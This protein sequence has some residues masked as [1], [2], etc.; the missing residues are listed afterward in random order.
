MADI[1]QSPLFLLTLSLLMFQCG[2][3][4]YERCNHF[5]LL[6]PT[7]VGAILIAGLLPQLNINYQTYF[8][9]NHFLLFW[10]GPTTVALAVP[11]YQQLHLI[12]KMALPIFIT[13][14]TGAIFAALS[15]V[16]LA[17]LMGAN[18]LT[19]LSIA[20][21]SVTTPIAMSI[22]EEV[23]GLA[24]LAAGVVAI[25]AVSTTC[26]S[27]YVFRLLKITDPK[28][29]GFCLGITAHGM[30]TATAFEKNP[31]AGTFSSLAMCLT[32]AFSALL[33][34]ITVSLLY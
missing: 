31:T 21:K 22:A 14:S 25:T 19:L 27:P 23:G 26:F 13:F 24:S 3:Y 6:H 4:L 28:I 2:R 29:W 10:L 20:P 17:W 18:K 32:G 16:T 9:G 11:M 8:E 33:I 15:T 1:L 7:L 12:R 34:P 30:G 5:A